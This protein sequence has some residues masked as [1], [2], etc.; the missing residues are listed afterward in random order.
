MRASLGR[1]VTA[2]FIGT[3]LL[4]ATVVGSGI[5]GER[6]AAGN[7]AVALLANTIAIGAALVALILAFG[8]ISGAHFNSV[9]TF[10]DA[11]TSQTQSLVP[12]DSKRRVPFGMYEFSSRKS[13]GLRAMF[14]LYPW[15]SDFL[16]ENDVSL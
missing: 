1:R 9:V 12:D 4:V 15:S 3:L 5:M 14:T 2:E 10:M 13:R 16:V 7:V 8:G 11:Q 6:L